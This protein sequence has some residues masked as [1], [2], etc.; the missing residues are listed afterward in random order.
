MSESIPQRDHTI[1]NTTVGSEWLV[2][3]QALSYHC[4]CSPQFAHLILMASAYVL[5][6]GCEITLSA[7]FTC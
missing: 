7:L 3:V 5:R 4:V 1:R 6:A 2:S